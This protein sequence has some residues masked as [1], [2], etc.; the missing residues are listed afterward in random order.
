MKHCCGN[1]RWWLQRERN[2][3]NGECRG[4]PGPLGVITD[5]LSMRMGQAIWAVLPADDPGCRNFD[6]VGRKRH[7]SGRE[8]A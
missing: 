5:Q 1:C 2:A 8:N 4:T 6:Y 3:T 7:E